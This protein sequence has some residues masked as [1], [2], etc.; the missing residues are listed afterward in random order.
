MEF[1]WDGNIFFQ[2]S[3]I[4]LCKGSVI[5]EGGNIILKIP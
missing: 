4:N 3:L 5:L 2:N 1:L